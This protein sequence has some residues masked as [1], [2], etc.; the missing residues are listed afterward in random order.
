MI[1]IAMFTRT[2]FHDRTGCEWIESDAASE[3]FPYTYKQNMEDVLSRYELWAMTRDKG[4]WW[5]T[6]SSYDVLLTI[7]PLL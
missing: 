3:F 2:H 1:G 6:L 7:G 4:T 5:F